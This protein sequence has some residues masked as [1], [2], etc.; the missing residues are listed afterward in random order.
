MKTAK[1]SLPLATVP[2]RVRLGCSGTAGGGGGGR[3]A[4]A[5]AAAITGA[6]GRRDGVNSGRVRV[7]VSALSGIAQSGL[8]ATVGASVGFAVTSGGGMA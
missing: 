6:G 7:A 4:T 5:G 2:T 1:P 3:G 8:A